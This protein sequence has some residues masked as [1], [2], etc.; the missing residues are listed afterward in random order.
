MYWLISRRRKSKKERND[1]KSEV[2]YVVGD[3]YKQKMK[4]RV[5]AVL[6][7]NLSNII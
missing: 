1:V 3:K 5:D 6:L 2:K 7:T 4:A